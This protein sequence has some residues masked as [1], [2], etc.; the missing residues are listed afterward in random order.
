MSDDGRDFELE[1]REDMSLE[2][3]SSLSN[4]NFQ[5]EEELTVLAVQHV[6]LKENLSQVINEYDEGNEGRAL[7]AIGELIRRYES[8]WN[9]LIKNE[10]FR[11][12]AKEK[13]DEVDALDE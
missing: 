1:L 13:F 9:E 4:G 11:I 3:K 6:M 7:A 5:F 2:D 10:E 8:I 12:F